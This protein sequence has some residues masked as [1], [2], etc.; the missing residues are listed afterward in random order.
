MH[1]LQSRITVQGWQNLY[2]KAFADAGYLYDPQTASEEPR[3][4]RQRVGNVSVEDAL[5]YNFRQTPQ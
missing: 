1:L 4:S 5:I 2:A 3:L